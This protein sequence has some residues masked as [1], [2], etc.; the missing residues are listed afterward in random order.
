VLAFVD[1]GETLPATRGRDRE[2]M[3]G[4][5]LAYARRLSGPAHDRVTA[6]LAEQGTAARELAALT[7]RKPWRRAEAAYR[8]GDMVFSGAGAALAGALHDPDSD[9]RAAAARSL[10][11]LRDAGCTEELLRAVSEHR[12]PVT[13]GSWA[14]LRI[15]PPALPALRTL[16]SSPVPALRTW[17]VRLLGLL[18]SPADASAV[19]ER[20]RDTAA[21]VREQAALALGRLGGAAQTDALLAALGDRVPAVR[22]A[23]A[24]ALGRRHEPRAAGPLLDHARADVFATA[25]AA[26]YALVDTDPALAARHAGASPSLREACDL[27]ALR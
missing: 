15:G 23:A 5:L 1:T 27:A 8:L 10:G 17:A 2:V 22:S 25:R 18:G 21:T 20:L 19:T 16:T 14:L 4:M 13:V 6:Y 7:A 12:V 24:T 11:R 9:V 3:T 26:A